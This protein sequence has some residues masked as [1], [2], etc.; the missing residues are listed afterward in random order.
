MLALLIPTIALAAPVDRIARL[1][2][3][4]SWARASEVCVEADI[5]H[6]D[7][8]DL[9]RM[10][11]EAEYNSTPP[12][13]DVTALLGFSVR[14][15]GTQLAD[16]CFARA[17]ELATPGADAN[18]AQLLR[19][20]RKYDGTEAA[21][22][23]RIRA[24]HLARDDARAANTWA[25]WCRFL[26]RYTT[27]ELRDSA[28]RD[29]LA[30]GIRWASEATD[31]TD[32]TRLDRWQSLLD[33]LPAHRAAIEAA[34]ES[35][36]LDQIRQRLTGP[37][38]TTPCSALSRGERITIPAVELPW[39]AGLTARWVA[40]DSRDRPLPVEQVAEALGLTPEELDALTSITAGLGLSMWTAPVDWAQPPRAL[41]ATWALQLTYGTQPPSRVAAQMTAHWAP[42]GPGGRALVH[43]STRGLWIHGPGGS[44]RWG[45]F[46]GPRGRPT[47]TLVATDTHLYARSEGALY[48][49]PRH[50]RAD[51][52]RS[53]DRR[54]PP[55]SGRP[56]CLD[57]SGRAPPALRRRRLPDALRCRHPCDPSEDGASAASRR[58][59]QRGAVECALGS[60]ALQASSRLPATGSAA[61]TGLAA[62]G[63]SCAQVFVLHP[64]DGGESHLLRVF[65]ASSGSVV[66]EKRF[67]VS[68]SRYGERIGGE[69]TA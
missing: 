36:A 19:H 3:K 48:S 42:A 52:A 65:D 4:Q 6:A 68:D 8:P 50:R 69:S 24:E 49:V 27:G 66:G 46:T 31:D 38:W 41:N 43:L 26:E 58:Q 10:C 14:W 67:S 20:S 34:G 15:R 7:D 61:D 22:A 59:R 56:L 54:R 47:G 5:A 44:T 16:T 37:C 60:G 18:E 33:T 64:L 12:S 17:A 29:A 39:N 28:E 2:E 35:S 63:T 13:D 1:H 30:V 40:V 57:R 11:A 45:D 9:R 53:R 55:A 25:A 21:T 51:R 32:D 23:S 62:F